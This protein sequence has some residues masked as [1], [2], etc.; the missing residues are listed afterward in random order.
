MWINQK[1]KLT[2]L[3]MLREQMY[4]PCYIFFVFS[5]TLAYQGNNKLA[6]KLSS[7]LEKHIDFDAMEKY[8][9]YKKAA[10]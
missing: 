4:Y 3:M 8:K 9:F 2:T 10:G 6:Y 5:L 7:C 1:K